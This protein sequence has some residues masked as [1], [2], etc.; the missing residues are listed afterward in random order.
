MIRQMSHLTEAKRW[1]RMVR[2]PYQFR[3]DKFGYYV[4]RARKE[5]PLSQKQVN[6]LIVDAGREWT[7]WALGQEVI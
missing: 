2:L 6:N 7:T 5:H 1:A 4:A 3:R